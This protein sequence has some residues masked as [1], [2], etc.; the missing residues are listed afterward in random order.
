MQACSML[1]PVNYC[2]SCRKPLRGRSDKKFCND[3]CRSTHH[4]QQHIAN[5]TYIRNINHHLR[6]NHRILQDLLAA[7]KPALKISRQQLTGK[8]F[9]FYYH[10]HESVNRRG[11]K[12]FF[13]YELGYRLLE[14]EQVL[15]VSD[16]HACTAIS[17]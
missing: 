5:N 12:T 13:C 3:Y 1:Q 16:P 4:N 8:G 7:A 14:K 15:I 10:T 11:G 9:S 2:H 17:T 6:K